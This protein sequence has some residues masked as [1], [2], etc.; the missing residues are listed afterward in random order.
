MAR[1][2]LTKTLVDDLQPPEKGQSFVWDSEVPGF[3]VRV[4]PTGIKASIVQTRVR[5]G[6]ER[7]IAIGFCSK[8]PLAEAR[9]E[10]KKLIA[11]ADL[12]R[13]PAQERKEARE[14]KPDTD[15]LFEDFAERWLNEVV[16][17]RNRASTL[18][19]RRL[20]V[21]NHVTPHIGTEHLSEIGR[22]DIEDM[23]PIHAPALIQ[24]A[25]ADAMPIIRDVI[26]VQLNFENHYPGFQV[27][28]ILREPYSGRSF[29]GFENI[30]LS[31]EELETL[32]RNNRPDWKAALASVKGIYLISDITTGKHYIGSA[33]GDQGIWSRWCAYVATGHGGNAELRTLV[34]DPTLDYC[35]KSFR[36]ALLEFRPSVTSDDVIL[37]RESFWKRILLTRGEYGLNRN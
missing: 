25:I 6:K 27:Q 10:A 28:E 36:F 30:D 9:Q 26:V 23:H 15:P 12:G 4:T 13:D 7:R 3:G 21:K 24:E 2:R 1:I 8:V 5:L 31:F 37:M 17:T 33:S 34:S 35:R 22:K 14:A 16:A 11:A 19:Y 18:K 29:P 20:L 32:V